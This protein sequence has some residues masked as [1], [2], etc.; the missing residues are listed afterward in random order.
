M[1][2]NRL[3]IEKEAKKILDKFSLELDKVREHAPE[4]FVERESD[5]RIEKQGKECDKNFRETIFAN[6]PNKE[7]DFIISEKGAWTK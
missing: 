1:A 5:R 7:G 4:A 6:A 2:I 3:E